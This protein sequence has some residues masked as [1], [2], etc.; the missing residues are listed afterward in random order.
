MKVAMSY[1]QDLTEADLYFIVK[2]VVDKRQDYDYIVNLLK[3]KPD[4]VDIM[5]EDEKLFWRVQEEEDIFLKISPFLLFTI[6]LLQTK[7]DLE[8]TSYTMEIISKKEWIPVFDTRDTAALL[9]NK[10]LRAYLARILASF[11]KV[12]STTVVYRARGLT[13]QR[14]FSELNFDDVLELA[15]LV[16]FP[17][18]YDFYKRLADISLFLTGIFPEYL[19]GSTGDAQ[20]L[21][22]FVGQGK[23]SIHDYEEEG[24]RY[25]DLAATYDEAR[26]QGLDQVLSLLAEKFTTARKP[27]NYLAE[28][29]IYKY[30][31]RWFA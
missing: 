9:Q 13:Y 11:T 16:D 3:D 10:D 20:I 7:R 5:L 23:R 8:R 26:E 18:R 14:Q 25:Y 19:S 4:L 21:S 24:R 28:N 27:L 31:G 2:T 30:R 12:D 6:L 1:L 29:F 15:G 22:R 17:Y